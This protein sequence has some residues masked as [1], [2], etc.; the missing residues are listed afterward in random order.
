MS[1]AEDSQRV[2]VS[3]IVRTALLYADNR[4]GLEIVW[5]VTDFTRIF[6]PGPN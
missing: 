6:R 4:V 1:G 2:E 3:G 5:G